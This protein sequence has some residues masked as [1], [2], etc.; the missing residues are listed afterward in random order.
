MYD[1]FFDQ[2]AIYA[3]GV[4]TFEILPLVAELKLKT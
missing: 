1:Y 2:V 3:K 4:L